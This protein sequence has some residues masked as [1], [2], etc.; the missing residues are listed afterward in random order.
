MNKELTDLFQKGAKLNHVRCLH[1]ANL[2]DVISGSAE[3][4]S[5]QQKRAEYAA[6]WVRLSQKRNA[7]KWHVRVV[8]FDDMN[9]RSFRCYA[10]LA[11]EYGDYKATAAFHETK[12][13]VP[14][15]DKLKQVTIAAFVEQHKEALDVFLKYADDEHFQSLQKAAT[16]I[17]SI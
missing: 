3:K 10:Q 6:N 12:Y 2:L 13:D 16:F 14:L 4:G 1:V 15:S 5:E 8:C 7:G 17:N 11:N 9:N